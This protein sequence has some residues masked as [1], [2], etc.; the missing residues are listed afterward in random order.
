M[1][2]AKYKE[3]RRGSRLFHSSVKAGNWAKNAKNKNKI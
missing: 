3:T 1:K 2:E